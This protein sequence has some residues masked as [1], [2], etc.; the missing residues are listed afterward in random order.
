MK[1][2][3]YKKNGIEVNN[4]LKSVKITYD[5]L[6]SK[7]GADKVYAFYGYDDM[8]SN[9]DVQEMHRGT[10]GFEAIIPTGKNNHCV[11]VAFKDSANNWDNNSN[12]NYSFIVDYT[13]TDVFFT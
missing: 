9:Q 12:R 4:K 13:A 8:W 10:N 2:N 7:S 6:L 3:E 11:N 5:G 1:K